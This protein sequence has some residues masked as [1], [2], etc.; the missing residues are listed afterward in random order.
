MPKAQ[1]NAERRLLR[2]KPAAAYLSI[3]PWQMRRLVQNGSIPVVQI[4]EGS[5]WLIDR[6]DLDIFVDRH[7]Q[8]ID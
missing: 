2:L 7:K 6:K 4:S 3:S 5:P 8:T 1:A